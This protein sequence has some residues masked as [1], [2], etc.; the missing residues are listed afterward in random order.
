V[1]FRDPGDQG[2]SVKRVIAVEG[3]SILIKEG[4]VYVNGEALKE[5]YLMSNVKTYTYSQAKEQFITLG[6][7]QYF[8][9]GDNRMVSIDSRSYGPVQRVDILGVVDTKHK[10]AI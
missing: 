7:G 1:V 2:L 8:L 4:K 5:E 9:L 10:Y 6:Q 3:E